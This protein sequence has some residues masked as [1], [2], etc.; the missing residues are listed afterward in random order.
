[1][2]RFSTFL[3]TMVLAACLMQWSGCYSTEF[4]GRDSQ[5]LMTEKLN[6]IKLLDG[7]EIGFD[8]KGGECVRV[9][10]L[11]GTSKSGSP[12]KIT[13]DRILE[14]R[15][16]RPLPLSFDSACRGTV[17]EVLLDDSTLLLLD[18]PGARFDSVRNVFIGRKR[19]TNEFIT[20]RPGQVLQ[21]RRG[22][23]IR[24]DTRTLASD[25]SIHLVEIVLANPRY[26]LV[27]FDQ[28]GGRLSD[29]TRCIFG[30]TRYGEL[31][32]VPLSEVEYG[33]IE[34]GDAGKTV[35]GVAGVMGIL[36]VGLGVMFM[37]AL[38]SALSG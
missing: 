34:R 25:T 6:S 7:S 37:I 8:G 13:V 38:G 14:A 12:V 27:E 33:I 30:Q 22:G 9:P 21:Y 3:F 17:A 18:R 23:A 5:S 35:L 29:S 32:H 36:A 19:G 11:V 28:R 31:V 1:M 24:V 4:V 20:F 10:T 16:W 26:R 15:T 2:P